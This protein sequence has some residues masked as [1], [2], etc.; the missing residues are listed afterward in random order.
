MRTEKKRNN[1]RKR[2]NSKESKQNNFTNIQ[3]TQQEHKQRENE[4]NTYIVSVF[5]NTC[6]KPCDIVLH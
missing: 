3:K 1:E 2:K 6:T 5:T 4:I